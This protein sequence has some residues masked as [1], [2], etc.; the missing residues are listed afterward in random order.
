MYHIYSKTYI[1]E[2]LEKVLICSRK[3]ELL[4]LFLNS[5]VIFEID[6]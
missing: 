3:L 4:T 2:K 6:Y 1:E 5:D